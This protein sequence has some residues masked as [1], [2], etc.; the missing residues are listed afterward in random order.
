MA[1]AVLGIGIVT[2]LTGV[3]AM[4]LGAREA[5]QQ[6]WATCAVRAE[7]GALEAAPWGDVGTYPHMDSV[8]L[9]LTP[10]GDDGL[11]IIEVTATDPAGRVKAT[12]TVL[13]AR[14]LSGLAPPPSNRTSPGAWCS[15]LLRAAP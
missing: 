3:D 12:A 8:R 6:A 2:A 9:S 10:S 4:L 5:T 11:Q 13:K 15:Y 7:A 14:A 1:A